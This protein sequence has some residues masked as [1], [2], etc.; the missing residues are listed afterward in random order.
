MKEQIYTKNTLHSERDVQFIKGVGP[1][2]AQALSKI[3]IDNARDLL[4][5]FPRRY[6]DRS[7]V[8]KISSLKVDQRVTVV[9]EIES[10]N[11]IRTRRGGY[12]Q[13]L[14]KDDTG[15]LRCKWFN[16][17]KYIQKLFKEGE[18]VA[19]SGKV[20]YY[21]GY[22]LVHPDY[23]KIEEESINT[24][25]IVPLYSS[26]EHLKKMY[27]NSKGFRRLYRKIFEKY[28]IVIEELL[29]KEIREKQNLSDVRK[30][31]EQIHFPD[32]TEKLKKARRRFIFE[33]LFYLQ[34]IMSLKRES[35]KS[36]SKQF[37]YDSPGKLLSKIY[38]KLPF[39]LTGAQKRVVKEIWQDM[40][41]DRV[42]NRLVQ[43]DVGSGKTVVAMLAAS[44]AIGNGYQA[45]IMA[46]T[47]ILAE[48]HY[49]N[50]KAMTA[51][52]GINTVLLVGNQ[53]KGER[54]AI[55]EQ[56]SKNE[57]NLII[58]TH[59]LIQDSVVI[60][61]LSLVIID[62]QHRFGVMQRG[63]L[64]NKG[65]NPDVLVMTA[66]PI[67]R[68]MSMTLYGDM[69]I[70]TIEETPARKGK[71]ITKKVK[72]NQLPTVYDF[73]KNKLE[74]GQQAYVV[75][76]LIAES[77]KM[78]LKA[79]ETGYKKLNQKIFRDYSVALLHGQ[80]KNEEKEN[81]MT[82]FQAGEFDILVSTTVIEVGVDNPNA[83][84][85]LIENA[86]RYGLTQI[87][88][89]RGRVGRGEENGICVLVER[90]SSEKAEKRLD[91]LCSTSDGFKISRADLKLR[92][93][94]E[95]FSSKQH[96]YPQMKIAD[97]IRDRK[98][99]ETARKEAYKLIR[100]DPHLRKEKH[101]VVRQHLLDNY[102]KYMK[103]VDVL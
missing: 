53:K 34:L 63:K 52:L 33:E 100:I 68:T 74:E 22:E 75:Y 86:E 35:I 44:I 102:Q 43:G 56:I 8:T 7:T 57:A 40:K 26:T 23:D 38:E 46:P 61:K 48:Q 16:S 20:N 17:A 70:S 36:I 72:E 60:D 54:E 41:S 12:F 94:G 10:K 59:A 99:L 28:A 87:H 31:L 45:A 6:L 96:G 21:K 82:R 93:P 13:L 89:L 18:T 66:T 3:G 98:I 19:F 27:L 30:A 4:Y 92:G 55:L 11:Y 71:I 101:Q 84:I 9:G 25:R 50:L 62:E 83:N 64:I 69:D 81:I 80:M 78:D 79:A 15:Y 91:I 37:S 58:G 5:H 29:P 1:K 67:P 88:Q 85:M 14:V 49:Q 95:F 97:L 90:N 77:E 47:E 42:M 51:G 103:Y 2:R 76:P 32:N 73:I 65:L 39:E 24:G